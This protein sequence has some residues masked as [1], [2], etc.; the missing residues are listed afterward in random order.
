M[1]I[2]WKLPEAK[3]RLLSTV[4]GSTSNLD[5]NEV[6]R[7]FGQG[8]T[9]DAIEG[10]LRKA[11]KLANELK[12]EA[13]GRQGPA[14]AASRSKKTKATASPAKTSVKGARV[15]KAKKTSDPKVKKELVEKKSG[16][17]DAEDDGATSQEVD[18]KV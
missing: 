9:Y 2:Q 14:L 4:T 6:A 12:Q 1:P 15:T 3:D 8:A 17:F 7:L 5:M 18:E 16:L 13:A 11:K 10:Q